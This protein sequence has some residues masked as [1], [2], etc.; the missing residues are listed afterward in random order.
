MIRKIVTD[1]IGKTLTTENFDKIITDYE[2]EHGEIPLMYREPTISVPSV[3]V[4]PRC[5]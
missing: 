3:I 2:N 4:S 1:E 5:G